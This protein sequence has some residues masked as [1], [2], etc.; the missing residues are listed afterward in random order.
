MTGTTR[1][2][3]EAALDAALAA[4]RAAPPAV[5]PALTARVLA[6]AAA[7][8]ANRRIRARP[9]R[10][11]RVAA[12]FAGTGWAG[13]GLG[14]A[15]AA[16][17]LMIGLASP[18]PFDLIDLAAGEVVLLPEGDLLAALDAEGWP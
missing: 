2:D 15:A 5:P 13:P 10:A 18:V 6:D 17:G 7:V 11:A 16:A 4:L 14:I 8:Q 1:Q 12:W 9:S 3:D